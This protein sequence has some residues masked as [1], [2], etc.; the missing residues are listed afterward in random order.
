M[1]EIINFDNI[2][3]RDDRLAAFKKWLEDAGYAI[4]IDPVTHQTRIDFVKDLWL[5]E[6]VKKNKFIIDLLAK[7]ENKYQISVWSTLIWEFSLSTESESKV[8]DLLYDA[9]TAFT[10]LEYDQ[11]NLKLLNLIATKGNLAELED[12]I[13]KVIDSK[14]IANVEDE[15]AK[16]DEKTWYAQQLLAAEKRLKEAQ[17]RYQAVNLDRLVNKNLMTGVSNATD[18]INAH[19]ETV[20]QV[21]ESI[22]K[23]SY[24]FDDPKLD[25]AIN[26]NI[27][28]FEYVESM[29]VLIQEQK[30]IIKKIYKDA[31][32]KI[33]KELA[34]SLG[35]A[36]VDSSAGRSATWP[37]MGSVAAPS[38]TTTPSSTTTASTSTAS[39]IVTAK[40]PG[41]KRAG[42]AVSAP[43]SATI[44]ASASKARKP[45]MVMNNGVLVP[46]PL[47]YPIHE[48]YRSKVENAGHYL[49][50]MGISNTDIEMIKK[51]NG[52]KKLEKWAWAYNDFI[53][54]MDKIQ[55][56]YLSY[57]DITLAPDQLNPKA[58]GVEWQIVALF[59]S[60]MKANDTI[61]KHLSYENGTSKVIIAAYGDD[62][63]DFWHQIMLGQKMTDD[64]RYQYTTSLWSGTG[65]YEWV[66]SLPKLGRTANMSPTQIREYFAGLDGVQ[67]RDYLRRMSIDQLIAIESSPD[68]QKKL[69]QEIIERALLRKILQSGSAS[70]NKNLREQIIWVDFKKNVAKLWGGNIAAGEEKLRDM[71]D[72]VVMD[73]KFERDINT[74]YTNALW[75]LEASN[76]AIAA[77]QIPASMVDYVWLTNPHEE[78]WLLVTSFVW[79]LSKK[80]GIPC[81][82]MGNIMELYRWPNGI[83]P[84]RAANNIRSKWK[85]EKPLWEASGRDIAK[86]GGLGKWIQN[87]VLNPGMAKWWISPELN[88][89]LVWAWQVL[90]TAAKYVSGIWTLW[91]FGRTILSTVAGVVKMPF[92]WNYQQSFANAADHLRW[93]A[94]RWWGYAVTKVTVDGFDHFTDSKVAK[95]L[96][97][98]GLFKWLVWFFSPSLAQKR[99]RQ[100]AIEKGVISANKT[101]T[102]IA[103]ETMWGITLGELA[104][105]WVLIPTGTNTYKFDKEAF[106]NNYMKQLRIV[107]S[108]CGWNT[109]VS[110]IVDEIAQAF[111][112][113]RLSADLWDIDDPVIGGVSLLGALAWSTAVSWLSGWVDAANLTD[114]ALDRVTNDLTNYGLPDS[115]TAID[116]A[117][118][119]AEKA[120]LLARSAFVLQQMHKISDDQIRK[121][122]IDTDTNKAQT[123][124][125]A[126]WA[127]TDLDAVQGNRL[128]DASLA[129][130]DSSGITGEAALQDALTKILNDK[131]YDITK[132]FKLAAAV[133]G[134]NK[135]TVDAGDH[136]LY[137]A[138]P[139]LDGR[140]CFRNYL[141]WPESGWANTSNKGIGT[142]YVDDAILWA[143]IDLRS[144]AGTLDIFDNTSRSWTDLYN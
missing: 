125:P 53:H 143:G 142:A 31:G 33:P 105:K 3:R 16:Y 28:A 69:D 132:Y 123:I 108:Q 84:A 110:K 135:K 45:E 24:Y 15:T 82:Q 103:H 87:K 43:I 10:D 78:D 89:A 73:S 29:W 59:A 107:Q 109:T 2:E 18:V 22:K 80:L 93:F 104:S 51:L 38:A 98:G 30:D 4:T 55:E 25:S 58:K 42:T 14:W 54:H 130:T 57:P 26:S 65:T 144:G 117:A 133:F 12:E 131:N 40:Y 34:E 27:E 88:S 86:N 67:R 63:A 60:A 116:A 50:E 112:D 21:L 94:K 68:H 111:V 70:P 134:N 9:I 19:Q 97:L 137:H 106:K 83:D 77:D 114:D 44:P 99:D 92:G 138:D 76:W 32:K 11:A 124:D 8:V 64:D 48:L 118:T 62:S 140:K 120:E 90:W 52:E 13:G 20:G 37:S 119:D 126:T 96:W 79:N 91:N 71:I 47:P 36:T 56:L 6:G 136:I 141:H 61:K 7:D 129:I 72:K 100:D 1:P 128:I 66:A 113:Q 85:S 74:D 139:S 23:G 115:R 102:E 95:K 39:S 122:Y 17:E 127:L 121:N 101:Y 49:S 75:E 35:I 81:Q 5:D 41:T 46:K